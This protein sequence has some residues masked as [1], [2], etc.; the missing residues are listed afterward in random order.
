M[1]EDGDDAVVM[2]IVSTNGNIFKNN[3]V[4][5]KLNVTVRKGVLAITTLAVLRN[6]FGAS[7]HLVWYSKSDTDTDFVQILS[8]DSRLSNDGFTLTL[9]PTDVNNRRVFQCEVQTN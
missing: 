7:A 6:V 3:L 2:E 4:N 8:S 1:G 5:T 9:T